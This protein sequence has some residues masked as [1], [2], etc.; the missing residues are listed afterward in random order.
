MVITAGAFF[1]PLVEEISGLFLS[2][3]EC[4]FAVFGVYTNPRFA[5]TVQ[6]PMAVR[7]HNVEP[8]AL[9]VPAKKH[10]LEISSHHAGFLDQVLSNLFHRYHLSLNRRR[11][12]PSVLM[13]C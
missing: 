13:K 8:S 11:S 6:V 9:V 5:I 3:P 10:T 12:A 7:G 1:A 2:W 4:G